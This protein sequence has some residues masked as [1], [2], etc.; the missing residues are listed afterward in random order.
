MLVLLQLMYIGSATASH[1]L[2]RVAVDSY[3]RVRLVTP[4]AIFFKV[5][6]CFRA[7]MVSTTDI[8]SVDLLPGVGVGTVLIGGKLLVGL[9]RVLRRHDWED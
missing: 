6:L 5:A 4:L 2:Q 8:L 1:C 3:R 7:G 9:E